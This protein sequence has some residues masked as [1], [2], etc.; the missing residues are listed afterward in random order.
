MFQVFHAAAHL[1]TYISY[2]LCMHVITE[3]QKQPPAPL[4]RSMF[5]HCDDYVSLLGLLLLAT[6]PVPSS[7]I[8]SACAAAIDI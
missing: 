8:V 7:P 1:W 3:G 5:L 2:M 6:E 4:A